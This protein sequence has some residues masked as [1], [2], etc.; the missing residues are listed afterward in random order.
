M[1]DRGGKSPRR[2][3]LRLGAG[4]LILGRAGRASRA[5]T[6][7]P[8]RGR[9]ERAVQLRMERA[10]ALRRRE[11]VELVTNGDESRYADK[12]ASYSKGLPHDALGHVDPRA[13][14]ALTRALDSGR[15]E[16]F[17]AIPTAGGLRLVNPQAALCYGLEGADSSQIPLPAPPAFDSAEQA[18]EACELYWQALT[19]DVP[20][21]AY[22]GDPVV[23][24]A[25]R[26]LSR[27]SG[28]RGPK[29]RGAV[30]PAVLFRGDGPGEDVGPYLSQFLWKEAPY[31]AVRLQQQVWTA[32]PG[33][34][35]L[36]RYDDWLAVQN[37]APNPPRYGA[38]Y[39]YIR[40]AR[41]LAAYVQF[42]F[43][44]QAFLTACLIL[45]GFES[46]Y[47]GS[48]FDAGNPYPPAGSQAGFITFGVVHV[49]DLVTR[50]TA[51]ALRACWYH[52]WAVHRRLR[53]EELG[54]RLHNH[55]SGAASSPLHPDILN[56]AAVDEVFSRHGTYLL[57]QAY[58]EG[59]PL[60]PSY[61][62][63]HA[64]VAG[65]CA[66]VMKAFFDEAARIDDPV[67]VAEDGQQLLRY[68]GPELRV[69]AEINKLASNIAMGRNAAGIH[70][71]SDMH[72]GLRLGE[73]VALA[74]LADLKACYNERFDGFSLTTFDGTRVT[75]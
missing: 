61:P 55:R 41:D 35:Y 37:G 73:S 9:V 57:Q 62:A 18:A 36:V 70:W 7:V 60:H 13:F 31:G 58:P 8:D 44:Y 1:S 11:A 47:K 67:V 23:S 24:R 54:G 29:Q 68:E 14:A 42:D 6:P 19:R 27:L 22:D 64:A 66:T 45:F 71:R 46:T 26:E 33:L 38:A 69:G 63:G 4:A 74:L 20:F 16:D 53:P 59:A 21:A 48:P 50:V 34:D 75:V 10:A 49:L 5:A 72:G 28:F 32:R 17:A 25:A 51:N 3:F 12:L 56:A 52:K 43:S 30:T 65:A 40:T 2:E 39:R 15:P